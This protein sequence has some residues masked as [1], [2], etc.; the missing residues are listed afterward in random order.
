MLTTNYVPGAPNWID[1]GSP[2]IGR[3][4]DFYTGLFGWTF[5]SLGPEAGNY[6]FFQLE[7][8]TVAALGPLGEQDA[9]SAWTLYFHTPD[10]DLTTKTVEQAGGKVRLAPMDV[11]DNGRMAQFTDPVGAQ[12][13][14]WQPGTTK[15]LDAVTVPGSLC[16]TELHTPD[17]VTARGFYRQVFG[18][19]TQDMPLPGG[20]TYTV[21]S[22]AGGGEEG[23]IGGIMQFGEEQL[24][25]G[26]RPHWLPYFEVLDAD[27]AV[28]KTEQSG[29][30]VLMPATDM[31]GVGRMAA[32]ADPFG[33]FFSVIKSAP[34]S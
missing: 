23:S 1:L 5:Q 21:L 18:W 31:E 25:A 33:A 24:A 30:Q 4:A 19:D 16:W 17:A 22:V 6:G 14:V 13:A 26:G 10:A 34:A 3:S 7:G 12:F 29:G 32:L 27:A 15:G 9:N 20:Q 8:K 11:F 2:D 28:A